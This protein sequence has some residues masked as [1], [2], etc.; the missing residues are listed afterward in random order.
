MRQFM[1]S[2]Q[3]HLSH[4]INE[5][6]K[7]TLASEDSWLSSSAI[8]AFGYLYLH[9]FLSDGSTEALNIPAKL[10]LVCA[11][12]AVLGNAGVDDF[13]NERLCIERR[14]CSGDYGIDIDDTI[15]LE[16]GWKLRIRANGGSGSALAGELLDNSLNIKIID[17]HRAA[18]NTLDDW[19]AIDWSEASTED[20]D[21]VDGS[22]SVSPDEGMDGFEKPEFSLVTPTGEQIALDQERIKIKTDGSVY[23]G[24]G[25]VHIS[26]TCGSEELDFLATYDLSECDSVCVGYNVEWEICEESLIR[27]LDKVLR[28]GLETIRQVADK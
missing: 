19:E 9:G 8:S 24:K 2:L 10:S 4:L 23:S 1:S 20:I 6:L 15:D 22:A 18:L 12:V 26:H 7:D 16:D 5:S 17:L 14:I 25:S 3:T 11:L 28:K 27:E 13:V 21:I